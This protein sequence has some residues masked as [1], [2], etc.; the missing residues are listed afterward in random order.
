[1][2]KRLV[3]G[4]NTRNGRK[5]SR[6]H[7]WVWR[8]R[9][10]WRRHG[11]HG[12]C[13]GGHGRRDGGHGRDAAGTGGTTTGAGGS[14]TGTGG[15]AASGG[16]AATGAGG[17][18]G[19][20]GGGAAGSAQGGA[21]GSSGGRAGGAAA[22]SGGGGAAGSG[23]RV[24]DDGGLPVD[25][26]GGPSSGCG[27]NTTRP[28]RKAQQTISIGG[29]T[30]Y[31]L[32]NVPSGAA[33]TP[34]PLVFALHGYDMN[35]V[36]LVDLYDF[37]AQSG[38]KAITVL[39][40]GEGPAPG[41]TSHWGDQVLKSTWMA[42]TA[43]YDFLQTLKADIQSKFCVDA[44]RVYMTG[45]SMGGFFTNSVACAHHDWFRGFAPVS[46]GGPGTCATAAAK[47][48][49]IIHHGTADT[50]VEPSSGEATR[51]FW[52]MRN[53]CNTMTTA[54]YTGCSSYGACTEPVIYCVGNWDHTVS[55]T[56][57]ANIWKFFDSLK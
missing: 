57:R 28:D 14:T 46:G 31:Y 25:G 20:G 42:N 54:I 48:P 26:G 39:P 56:A 44:S 1:M 23:G 51:D 7:R 49:I 5:R 55:A 24:G 50:I 17:A 41:N 9:W 36:A 43:N 29:T 27:K 53:G 45:F 15:T 37:T 34:L 30:R 3:A 22:G 40:Q 38:N 33:D 6:R 10:G 47:P 12:R 2:L 32:L 19:G 13:H 8:R 18:A 16:T 11:G 52:R 4:N 21:S 35:N